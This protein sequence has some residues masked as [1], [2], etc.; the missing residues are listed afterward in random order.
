MRERDPSAGGWGD[1]VIRLENDVAEMLV[2]CLRQESTDA[3]REWMEIN[4]E[5]EADWPRFTVLL[6]AISASYTKHNARVN[7]QDW[8]MSPRVAAAGGYPADAF[9]YVV[10][11]LNEDT[12]G[13]AGMIEGVLGRGDGAIEKL[14]DELVKIARAAILGQI[15]VVTS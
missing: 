5:T 9:R 1:P 4:F 3:L 8:A 6:G 11:H 15:G 14:C 13:L 10:M 2:Q 12:H 7:I